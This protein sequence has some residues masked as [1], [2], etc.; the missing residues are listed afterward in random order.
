MPLWG[1]Y[2]PV[3][4]E[5]LKYA[6][7]GRVAQRNSLVGEP[8][9]G[10]LSDTSAEPTGEI[11][12][13][14]GAGQM[15]PVRHEEGREQWS[16]DATGRCGIY[17]VGFGGK[18]RRWSPFAVNVDTIESDLAKVT[19]TQLREQ[20]WPG[21]TFDY[22]TTWKASKGPS[23]EPAAHRSAPARWLLCGGLVL[24][25]AETFLAWRFGHHGTEQNG[26]AS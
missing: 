3:V 5:I 10:V 18:S 23:P 15:L 11:R 25:I 24:L 14:D 22:R 8:L 6:A 21:V 4:R 20:V 13:P 2:V 17:E 12:L 19:E 7:S 9:E 16:F 26:K 1:S